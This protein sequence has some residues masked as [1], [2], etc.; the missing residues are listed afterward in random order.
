ML[1]S[2]RVTLQ[3]GFVLVYDEDR[4]VVASF[5]APPENSPASLVPWLPEKT[6]DTGLQSA[7]PLQGPLSASILASAQRN[8]Q[9]VIRIAGRGLRI[10]QSRY[11]VPASW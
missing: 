1:A 9:P 3:G 10:G 8:D 7:V 5:Q 11:R 2:H 4:H 6:G